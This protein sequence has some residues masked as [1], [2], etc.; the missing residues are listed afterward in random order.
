M[1][2]KW[3][4]V[5]AAVIYTFLV[6]HV[7]KT[8]T[9]ST[10]NER[11]LKRTEAFLKI[12]NDNEKLRGEL[13]RVLQDGLSKSAANN[14]QFTKELLDEIAKD[15]RYKS[16]RTTDGVRGALQRKLDSQPK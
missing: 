5:A 9:D 2:S 12:N 13:S 4:Y 6:A 8:Y 1:L 3:L 10:W 15:P 16:C 11:E 7:T 14:K